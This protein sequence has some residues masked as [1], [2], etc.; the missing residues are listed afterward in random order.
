MR[1][2]RFGAGSFAA[3][4]IGASLLFSACTCKIK[5]DQLATIKQLRTEEKQLTVDI[6][7]AEKS[8]TKLKGELTSRE[9]ETRRCNEQ[10]SFVQEKMSR[11]PNVWPDWDPSAPEPVVETPVPAPKRRR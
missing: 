8:A 1:N 3:L 10:K 6:E 5:E 4:A 7:S 9:S 2:L 11:W